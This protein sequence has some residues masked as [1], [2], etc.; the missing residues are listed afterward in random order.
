MSTGATGTNGLNNIPTSLLAQ[1]GGTTTNFNTLPIGGFGPVGQTDDFGSL[2]SSLTAT[3]NFG[4]NLYASSGPAGANPQAMAIATEA[5]HAF[6]H[7]LL[8]KIA[9]LDTAPEDLYSSSMFGGLNSGLS[10]IDTLS[11]VANGIAG[12][13]PL[14]SKSAKIVQAASP[15]LGAVGG[16]LGIF[17]ALKATLFRK[18]VVLK[19][20]KGAIEDYQLED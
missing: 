19:S 5:S 6:T 12:T 10:I 17:Q 13:L 8:H 20:S 11:S 3:G 15:A 4:P 7:S 9:P 16:V 18:P 2:L 1:L 14:D